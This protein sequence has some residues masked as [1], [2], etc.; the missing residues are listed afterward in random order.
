LKGLRN[1]SNGMVIPPAELDQRPASGLKPPRLQQRG[2]AFCS[3]PARPHST[4]PH[5]QRTP[6]TTWIST[7]L[8]TAPSPADR[9]IS[10]MCGSV[11]YRRVGPVR[12]RESRPTGA[13]PASSIV[14]VSAGLGS[15]EP[16]RCPRRPCPATAGRRSRI[17]CSTKARNQPAEAGCS[18][19]SKVS[20][21]SAG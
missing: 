12:G 20:V 1:L 13:I 7:A 16:E 6:E 8:A 17:R 10:R 18:T 2:G 5:L 19:R 21:R 11:F 9:M 4:S 3:A 15:P 14:S